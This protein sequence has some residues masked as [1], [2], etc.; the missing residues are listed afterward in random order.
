MLADFL[1]RF[2]NCIVHPLDQADRE[3]PESASD[4]TVE[5]C[6]PS[7]VVAALLDELVE[8]FFRR[9]GLRDTRDFFADVGWGQRKCNEC[10]VDNVGKWMDRTLLGNRCG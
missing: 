7:L 5:P 2:R 6:G 4:L 8:V 9:Q 3:I 10:A 1:K